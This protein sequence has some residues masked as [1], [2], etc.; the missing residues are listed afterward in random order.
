MLL[1]V[2]TESGAQPA[3]YSV[4][5]KGTSWE[6]KRPK[7]EVKHFTPTRF[8]VINVRTEISSSFY[9]VMPSTMKIF[10]YLSDVY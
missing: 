2:Q 6:L 8:E 1:Q 10:L 7:H 3:A 4:G 9:D 5:T